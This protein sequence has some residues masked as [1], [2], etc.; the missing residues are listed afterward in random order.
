MSMEPGMVEILFADDD[1]AMRDMVGDVLRHAGYGV[2]VARDGATALEL[3]RARPPT[4]AVLDYRMGRPDGLEVCRTLKS[5]PRLSHIPVLILTAQNR[6]EDRI[7]GFDAGADDYLPKPFDARELLARVR[8][9]LR[10][11]GDSLTRNPTTGLPGGDAIQREFER[12]RAGGLAFAACYF[13]LDNFKPF[14]D[15]FGFAIADAVIRLA[16]DTL[17]ASA[18]P[19]DFV[20]HVGGDDFV[21]LCEP[22]GAAERCE[23][24]AA[25]FAAGVRSLLPEHQLSEGRYRALDRE[26]VEREFPITRLSA[27]VLLLPGNTRYGYLELGEVLA[28]AKRLAKGEDGV[29]V[30]ELDG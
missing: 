24:V 8:A 21:L 4:L 1:A 3:A 19:T 7:D 15:R 25:S 18:G 2:R 16:G 10:L 29:A 14:G 23:Q 30:V 20:G 17:T 6:V 28:E 22:G 26:G 5:D 13:D 9:L 27:A 12:R 11:A